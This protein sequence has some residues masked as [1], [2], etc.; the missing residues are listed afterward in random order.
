MATA[1]TTDAH[2]TRPGGWQIGWGTKGMDARPITVAVEGAITDTM[3]AAYLEKYATKSTE[4]TGHLSRRLNGETIEVYANPKGSHTERLVAA[5]W[6]LGSPAEWRGLRLWAHVLG[7]G[8]HFLTKS[9]GYSV[10][11]GEL[12]RARIVWHQVDRDPAQPEAEA[13]AEEIRVVNIL[14]FAGA[15]WHNT[16]D[17]MLANSAAA[18]AREYAAIARDEM[19]AL[20]A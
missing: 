5:S 1:F 8:G 17:A 12:R 13:E 20:A 4:D 10:T 18:R 15:G 2:P 6:T 19:Y 9:R 7:F 11:F 16:G 14:Q 3:V